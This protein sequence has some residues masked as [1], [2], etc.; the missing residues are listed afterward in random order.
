[1]LAAL[2]AQTVVCLGCI[3]DWKQVTNTC[4]EAQL[5]REVPV[6]VNTTFACQSS[7]PNIS[8]LLTN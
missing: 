6:T 3:Y 5:R 4:W 8:Q 2:V 1:M 7:S